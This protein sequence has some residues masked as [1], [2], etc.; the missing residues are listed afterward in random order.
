M[1]THSFWLGIDLPGDLLRCV[2]MMRLPFSVPDS[3]PVQA[4]IEKLQEQGRTP[5]SAYQIPEAVIKFK[6]GF[7]RL[8]RSH[9]DR[10]I[11]AVLDSRI[12]TK[13]YGRNFL[14]SLPDCRMAYQIQGLAENYAGLLPSDG[15]PPAEE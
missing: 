8:I 13:P 10:G 6:Q 5:F 9:Q 2:I 4:R 11:V 3:P 1:G 12:I 7:G 14:K 15:P